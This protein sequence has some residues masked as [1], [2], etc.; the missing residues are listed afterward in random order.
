VPSRD[1]ALVTVG[2]P[3]TSIRPVRVLI[4]NLPDPSSGATQGR[5]ASRLER[6][7]GHT[8]TRRAAE[9]LGNVGPPP[10]DKYATA[11]RDPHRA[12]TTPDLAAGAPGLERRALVDGT[13]GDLDRGT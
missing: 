8:D 3:S 2:S 6:E 9:H 12:N 7:Q 10:H 4:A 11:R 5:L 1:A 13:R